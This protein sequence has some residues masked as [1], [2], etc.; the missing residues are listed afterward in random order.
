MAPAAVSEP[1]PD[2]RDDIRPRHQLQLPTA[3]STTANSTVNCSCRPHRLRLPNALATVATDRIVNNCRTC[4]QPQPPTA[5]STVNCTVNRNRR[6][7]RQQPPRAVKKNWIHYNYRPYRLQ[8]K[9]RRPPHPSH[10][11]DDRWKCA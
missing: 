1:I 4:W 5:P 6:S 3:I 8:T 2:N 7:H 9:T 10:I 11:H